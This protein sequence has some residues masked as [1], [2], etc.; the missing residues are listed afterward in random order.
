MV[1]DRQALEVLQVK[2]APQPLRIG[3]AALGAVIGIGVLARLNTLQL[4]RVVLAAADTVA[5][6]S[7]CLVAASVC[8]VRRAA[9]SCMHI[10]ERRDA[11]SLTL[12]LPP[13]QC[14][15][16]LRHPRPGV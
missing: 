10:A 12:E 8:E 3:G 14:S 9:P 4:P 15:L 13:A 2:L 1:Q 6:P 16:E 5:C 11:T 7:A